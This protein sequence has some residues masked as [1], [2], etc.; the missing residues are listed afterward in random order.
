MT[1][2]CA[3]LPFM[4][5]RVVS[6]RRGRVK[7]AAVLL[8]RRQAAAADAVAEGFGVSKMTAAELVLSGAD[9]LGLCQPMRGWAPHDTAPGLY[10]DGAVSLLEVL[11]HCKHHS[12]TKEVR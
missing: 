4:R 8:T 12:R 11:V 5:W 6:T 9:Y 3:V 7:S 1:G 2:D 10:E